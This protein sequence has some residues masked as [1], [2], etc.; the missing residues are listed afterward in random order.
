MY[1]S[2]SRGFAFI[3]EGPTE[4]VFYTQL[5][6]YLARKYKIELKSGYDEGDKARD[7]NYPRLK[8][9]A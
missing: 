5:L 3:V 9:Q 8:S 6:K 2:F 1:L 7:V 4:K